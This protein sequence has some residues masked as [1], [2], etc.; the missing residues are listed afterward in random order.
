MKKLTYEE[1]RADWQMSLERRGK[2]KSTLEEEEIKTVPIEKVKKGDYFRFPRGYQRVYVADGYNRST[3]K[4]SYYRFDDI[5]H[6]G[7]KKKGTVVEIGF[8]F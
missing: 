6:F 3:R 4:Y 1:F 2:L 8:D 5:N 7:E